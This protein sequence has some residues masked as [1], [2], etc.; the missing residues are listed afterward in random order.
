MTVTPDQM[1]QW[2]RT[3]LGLEAETA[4]LALSDYLDAIPRLD[5]L[6]DLPAGT[7][8]LVRGDVDC[9]PGAEIGQGDALVS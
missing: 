6:A 9:K 2:C 3:L 4:L 7:P 5:S 1:H 8:V